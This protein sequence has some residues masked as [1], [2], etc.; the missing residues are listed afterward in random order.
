LLATYVTDR[1]GLEGYADHAPPVTDDDPRIEYAPWVRPGELTR[2]LP[3]LLERAILPPLD[4]EGAASAAAQIETKRQQLYD[5]YLAGVSAMTGDR[6]TF[7]RALRDVGPTLGD[8][9]Y[10]AWFVEQGANVQ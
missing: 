7:A 10:F 6:E 9:A 8:N 1:Q 3:K 4:A 2:V 5:F